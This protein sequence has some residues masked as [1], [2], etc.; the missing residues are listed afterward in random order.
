MKDI[1]MT[2]I[3]RISRNILNVIEVHN[4]LED[5]EVDIYCSNEHIYLKDFIP[6]I[7]HIAM[8]H[9]SKDIELERDY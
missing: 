2:S 7:K 6:K 3:D 9:D 5:L 4:I 1:F 8:G